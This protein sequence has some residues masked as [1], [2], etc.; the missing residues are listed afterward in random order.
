MQTTARLRKYAVIYRCR[1][2]WPQAG[3]GRDA[4]PVADLETLIRTRKLDKPCSSVTAWV[5]RRPRL[6]RPSIPT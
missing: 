5:E 6:S 3:A 1:I 2:R 4:R